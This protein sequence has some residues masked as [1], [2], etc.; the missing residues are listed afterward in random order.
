MRSSTAI[1]LV[2]VYDN[3]IRYVDCEEEHIHEE[4]DTLIPNQVLRPIDEHLS[5]EIF[6][7]SPDTDG[8]VLLL[9]LVSWGRHGNLNN[10]KF[11]TGQS[12]NYREVDVIQR[13]QAIGIQKCQG[14]IGLHNFTRNRLGREVCWY[15][16]VLGRKLTW[17]SWRPSRDRLLQRAW[18]GSV[19]K[20]VSQRR[21]A[22]SSWRSREICLLSVLRR[23]GITTL[24]E[25]R[26]EVF[27]SRNLEG[28]MLPPNRWLPYS[29]TPRA[30][31]SWPC[32]TNPIPPAAWIFLPSKRMAGVNTKEHRFP[33]CA[34]LPAPQAV[35][36]LT[37]C[38]C[39][40]DCKGA[41]AVLFQE[42]NSMH[43]SL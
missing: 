43:S 6:V 19:Q 37:K 12:A 23:W 33:V 41:S 17:H 34:S 30:Q 3:K 14:L 9:D 22:H 38:G 20:P 27:R 8:K 32:A 26:W 31:S 5:Q 35:I 39:K 21:T 4:A 2:V 13:V 29:H 15:H 40:S 7:S 25:L 16:E 18:W 36:E 24:S 1:K 11:L 10:L 42:R 28:E